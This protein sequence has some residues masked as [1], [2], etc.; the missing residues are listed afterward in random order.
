MAVD[1]VLLHIADAA[2]SQFTMGT[3][4]NERPLD[5]VYFREVWETTA[6]GRPIQDV[7]DVVQ[8][9]CTQREPSY[10]H[11]AHTLLRCTCNMK[12]RLFNHL[13]VIGRE[14]VARFGSSLQYQLS[15]FRRL[16]PTHQPLHLK[17]I[18]WIHSRNFF[19]DHI[20]YYC[21]PFCFRIEILI[22]HYPVLLRRQC[23]RAFDHF[24]HG[25][26]TFGLRTVEGSLRSYQPMNIFL[27]LDI[28]AAA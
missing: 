14:P 7:I 26:A 15:K 22:H 27:K 1:V 11:I 3:L 25:E 12:D 24:A 9:T 20:A 10:F 8:D 21:P 23:P 6:L 4:A 5:H 2:Y 28:V 16:L 17:T 19:F 18:T 13:Q